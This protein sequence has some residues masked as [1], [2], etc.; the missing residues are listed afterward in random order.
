MSVARRVTR[1]KVIY[2]Y[3]LADGE[4]RTYTNQDHVRGY[5]INYI[6]D[7]ASVSMINVYVNGVLQLPHTYHVSKGKIRF[8]TADVPRQGAPIIVQSIRMYGGKG[9]DHCTCKRRRCVV[10]CCM[11]FHGCCH[12]SVKQG[13]PHC[14]CFVKTHC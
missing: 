13:M 14:L 3:T 5:G 12:L 7:P 8:R 2:F 11:P 4:K 10:C 9:G 1:T 6:P